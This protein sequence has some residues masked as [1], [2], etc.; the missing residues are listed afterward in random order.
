MS[1]R[2]FKVLHAR[3]ENGCAT[4]H[5]AEGRY[6]GNPSGAASKAFT[7]LCARKK[8]RGV[9]TLYIIIQETTQGSKKKQYCYRCRRRK[10]TNPNEHQKKWN[11]KYISKCR[12]CKPED[13]PNCPAT[14]KGKS[15]GPMKGL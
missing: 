4:K 13:I 15:S 3:R 1:D 9:C 8:I 2:H 10:I 6:S 14:Y 11:M 5:D 12:S 7:K